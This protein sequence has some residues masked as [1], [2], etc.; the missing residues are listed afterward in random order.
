MHEHNFHLPAGKRSGK[1]TSMQAQTNCGVMGAVVAHQHSC[2]M[3]W[4]IHQKHA[5]K[6]LAGGI[7]RSHHP[8]DLASMQLQLPLEAAT[9]VIMQYCE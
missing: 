5:C 4:M 6:Q 8:K 2:R 1:H 3:S 9:R 7:N